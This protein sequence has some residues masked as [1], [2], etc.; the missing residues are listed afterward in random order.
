MRRKQPQP[1][2]NGG[3]QKGANQLR[4]IGGQWR[5]RKLAF[6]TI[7]GL[8]PTPDRVRETLFNWLSGDI[9]SARCLDL[10]A[11]SGALGFEALSRGAAH[12]DMVD[13]A[14]AVSCQLQ[15]NAELL[16]AGNIKI[17]QAKALSFLAS[18][19]P[20]YDIIFLDPPF[21]QSLLTECLNAISQQELLKPGAWLYIEMG[22]DEPLPPL[23]SNWHLHREKSAGQ[24]CYRLFAIEH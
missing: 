2:K 13:S 3:S 24:V 12:V 18:Q 16:K 15:S 6:P 23:P 10:F 9:S 11:G 20:P 22:S 4:V 21:R 7:E 17:H 14:S 5:G 1:K 19:P 8:R